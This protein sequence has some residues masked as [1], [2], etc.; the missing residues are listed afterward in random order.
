MYVWLLL[1]QHLLRALGKP[2]DEDGEACSL[3]CDING[4]PR[5]T[6]ARGDDLLQ[7]RPHP[8]TSPSTRRRKAQ[9]VLVECRPHSP[10]PVPPVRV[11]PAATSDPLLIVNGTSL[12]HR[13]GPPDIEHINSVRES[14][15]PE[16]CSNS[17][18]TSA[19]HPVSIAAAQRLA[20]TTTSN[21]QRKSSAP[22][23]LA[24]SPSHNSG[25]G[26]SIPIVTVEVPRSCSNDALYSKTVS[27]P[28]NGLTASSD[29]G[30]SNSVQVPMTCRESIAP[31]G[32]VQS[33]S[34]VQPPVA[35]ANQRE[36]SATT[37]DSSIPV[38]VETYETNVSDSS[39]VKNDRDVGNLRVLSQ[40]PWF[41]G[42]ISRTLAS[43]LVLAG[44]D[45]R[46]GRYLVRQSESREGDFVLTFNYHNRAKVSVDSSKHVCQ[47]GFIALD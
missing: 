34:I 39:W 35:Q 11:G 23:L 22:S 10:I 24:T 21:H 27:V 26:L 8:S 41:H 7:M 33:E 38:Y 40:F 37:S 31:M 16:N 6:M 36:G 29:S 30:V 42:L 17:S 18:S 15:T 43:D 12:F 3:R 2:S 32:A 25:A 4:L 13:A 28:T 20:T 9:S 44:N 14:L 1:C 5:G 45:N 19:L 46:S 47:L